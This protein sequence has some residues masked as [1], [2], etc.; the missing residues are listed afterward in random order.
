L[1]FIENKR[2]GSGIFTK[3]WKFLKQSNQV[4]VAMAGRGGPVPA[5]SRRG[6]AMGARG[7]LG[8]T[9]RGLVRTYWWFQWGLGWFVV[10]GPW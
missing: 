2:K 9:K 6:K 7:S 1:K 4:L 5:K 10:V 8:K 3:P